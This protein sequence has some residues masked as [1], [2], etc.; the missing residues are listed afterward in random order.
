MTMLR[1]PDPINVGVWPDLKV[2]SDTKELEFLF[3]NVRSPDA[4]E[5]LRALAHIRLTEKSVQNRSPH[6][7][8]DWEFGPE[9]SLCHGA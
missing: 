2:K 5:Q 9:Y 3:A 6:A 4:L 1:R 8:R 7:K